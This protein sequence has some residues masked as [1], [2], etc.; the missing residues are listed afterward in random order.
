MLRRDWPVQLI[1]SGVSDLEELLAIDRQ[2]RRRIR[3]ISFPNVDPREDADMV[4]AVIGDY[5]KAAGLPIRFSPEDMIVPRLCHAA[6]YQFGLVMEIIVDAIEDCLTSGHDILTIRDFANAYTGR[7]LQPIEQNP[8]V[9]AAWHT[10]DCS[11][12]RRKASPNGDEDGEP[13]KRKRKGRRS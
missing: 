3:C 8:F 5:A 12:I 13:R 7:T 9:A 2:L 4:E 11:V 10:I 1:L 6:V